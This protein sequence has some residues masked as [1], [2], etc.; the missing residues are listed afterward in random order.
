MTQTA[1]PE[2]PP[3]NPEEEPGEKLLTLF[4][5]LQELRRRV[6]ISAVAVLVG[7]TVAFIFAGDIIDFLKQPAEDRSPDFQLQFIEPFEKF[8]AYFRVSMLGGLI[9]AMPVV[10]YQA[11]RFVTP[12][13]RPNERRWLVL[14]TIG[15]SVLF[16]IG[17]LFAYYLALPPAMDFLLNFGGE[18]IA[19]PNIRIG[20]YIDF[21]TRLLFWIGVAFETPIVVMFLAKFRIVRARQLIGWWRY[22][23]VV[24]FIIAAIVTPTPDPMTCTVVAVPIIALYFVGAVLAFLVQPKPASEE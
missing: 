1:P 23:I 22:A 10:V 8:G 3:E 12:G 9:L 20:S 17:V 14:T 16:I 13:L 24:A 11:L 6:T 21:V 18:D 7:M 19:R 15:A 4:E 5:H 2:P